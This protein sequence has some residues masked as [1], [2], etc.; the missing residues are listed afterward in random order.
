MA[1]SPAVDMLWGAQAA[2]RR[3][4]FLRQKRQRQFIDR[5]CRRWVREQQ[6]LL[7]RQ[8]VPL[9]ADVWHVVVV[10]TAV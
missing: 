1:P 10:E 2:E 5:R 8:R 4:A 7:Q 3:L 9:N 6:R